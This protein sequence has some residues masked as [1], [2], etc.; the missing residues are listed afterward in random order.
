MPH[1]FDCSICL[2]Y[3]K[4]Q[5]SD[6]KKMKTVWQLKPDVIKTLPTGLH[7]MECTGCGCL[8]IK[9]ITEIAI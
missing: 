9:M 3:A 5:G 2:N 8:G 7:L 1:Q 4:H 6:A